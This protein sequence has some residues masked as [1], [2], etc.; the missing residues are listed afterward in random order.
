[1][2]WAEA[3]EEPSENAMAKVKV[4]YIKNISEDI[5]EDTLRDKFIEFGL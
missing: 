3:Q 5:T 2:D 1:M 4:L